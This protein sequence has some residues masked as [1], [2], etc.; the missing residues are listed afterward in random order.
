MG[1][2]EH[3]RSSFKPSYQF[4]EVTALVLA[5]VLDADISELVLYLHV[6]DADS[7]ILNQLLDK[8]VPQSYVF[9]T[10]S[11]FG[12]PRRVKPRCCPCALV[13]YRR[14]YR[15]LAPSSCSKKV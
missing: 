6:V 10:S 4:D 9:T 11:R 1:D 14:L 8:E 12:Y 13:R 5:K 3:R 7:A 15:T 2:V